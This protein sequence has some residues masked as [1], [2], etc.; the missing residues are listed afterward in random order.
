MERSATA[1]DGYEPMEE[2]TYADEVDKPTNDVEGPMDHVDPPRSL[3]TNPRE[4]KQ[5]VAPED[6]GAAFAAREV[7]AS[8][9]A[10]KTCESNAPEILRVSLPMAF[11]RALL[12]KA[13]IKSEPAESAVTAAL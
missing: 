5:S 2:P 7:E 4:D 1:G 9:E 12:K 10:P 8:E 3:A 11:C 6:T 13:G